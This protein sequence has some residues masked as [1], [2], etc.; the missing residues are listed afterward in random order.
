MK[1]AMT[2]LAVVFL[3]GA[4][5]ALAQDREDR[6]AR[7]ERLEQ[8]DRPQRDGGGVR[9]QREWG[10]RDAPQAREAPRAPEAVAPPAASAEPRARF[11]GDGGQRRDEGWRDSD[12][13]EDSRRDRGDGRRD[14]DGRRDEQ[15]R[16]PSVPDARRDGDRRDDAQRDRDRRD[17]DGRDWDRRDDSRRDWDRRDGSR[18]DWDRRDDRRGD[19]RRW[20]RDRYPRVYASP[21][22]YRYA[23]RPPSG[24]YLRSWSYGEFF[25]RAWFGPNWWIVDPWRYDLPLPPPGYE[26]V[27][28]GSDALLIDEFSGRIVQVVRDVFWY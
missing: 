24:F 4:G 10:P 15:G 6:P 19:H 5:P 25:P 7:Q 20:E 2:A 9:P 26:W 14:W 16:Q 23:W 18:R 28:S 13:R 17:R 1:T 22:R 21:Y 3:A 12:R 11:R 8:R 27:R